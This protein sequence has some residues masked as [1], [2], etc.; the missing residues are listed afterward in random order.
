MSTLQSFHVG[1][2]LAERRATLVASGE[3][4]IASAVLLLEALEA[5]ELTRA[6]SVVIDLRAVQ[7]IDSSG[8]RALLRAN[9]ALGER[10]QLIPGEAGRRFFDIVGVTDTLP[11]LRCHAPEL[12]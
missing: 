2:E 8:L 4:D 1:L 7:F 3:L 11:L 5:P 12:G 9:E 6:A 10:L